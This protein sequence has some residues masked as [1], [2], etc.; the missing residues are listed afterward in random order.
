MK[1]L[2]RKFT[3]P[4]IIM[5]WFVSATTQ[6]QEF[7]FLDRSLDLD[8]YARPY[9][10]YVPPNYDSSKKWPIILFLHGAGEQGWDGYKQS[11]VG[12]GYAVRRYAQNF[13]AIVIFPQARPPFGWMDEDTE[14]A[15]QTL[16]AAE[17]EFSTDED[18][19]YLTGL[20]NGGYG[21]WKL[22]YK[23]PDRFAA[24]L[25]ICG[26]LSDDERYNSDV[27]L[28]RFN[29]AIK[30]N[31]KNLH[32]ALAERIQHLPVWIYHGDDDN[33]IDVDGSR[34]IYQELKNLGAP[35][36]YTELPGFGH[37]SWDVAYRSDST[38]KWL[39][40]QTRNIVSKN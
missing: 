29:P 34:K 28:P 14:F 33:V 12:L 2:I 23:Y 27:P 9:Q 10:I 32:Q 37:E 40:N 6:A 20:S 36:K 1:S 35:V 4:T 15:M 5:L 3:F 26:F 31:N 39:F 13:P 22:A 38:M 7:G 17:K 16:A 18:R 11:T 30:T 8:G 21:S 25:V 24:A 19:V